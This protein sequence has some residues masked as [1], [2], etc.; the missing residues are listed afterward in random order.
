MPRARQPPQPM[1]VALIVAAGSGERLGAGRPKAFVE[2]AGRPMLAV[3]L[4]ALARRAGDRAD[5]RRAASRRGVDPGRRR[6]AWS[7]VE[8]ALAL[9]LGAPRAR[10]GRRAATPCS[11]TT[12]RD[13]CSRRELAQRVIDALLADAGGRRGD[14]GGA[15]DRHD[16]ARGQGRWS[17]PRDARP[18]RALVGADPAGL[19]PRGARAGADVAAETLAARPTTPRWSS[20]PAGA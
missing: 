11:C 14:R 19:P 18:G 8:A 10:R 2:L 6:P 4:D 7:A 1:A 3:E 13:R 5:R 9:G 15:R 12:R 20:A 17:G 16:Q